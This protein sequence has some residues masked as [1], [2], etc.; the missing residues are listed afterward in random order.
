MVCLD[1]IV[2]CYF[3]T[4]IS[5]KTVDIIGTIFQSSCIWK[6]FSD[7]IQKIT[8][9]VC[10]LDESPGGVNHASGDGQAVFE[11]FYVMKSGSF[12][13]HKMIEST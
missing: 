9:R 6:Q 1:R 2:C 11:S 10:K 5:R 4:T 12:S 3:F 8:C 13:L 7:S